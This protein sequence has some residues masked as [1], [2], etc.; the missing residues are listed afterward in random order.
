MLKETALGIVPAVTP[1]INIS[2]Q[3]GELPEE[4]KIAHATPI[5]K[6]LNSIPEN[7][8]PISL[9]SALSKLLEMH[10]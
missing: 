2:I 4:W 1:L 6:S 10:V 8:C 9:L 7:Y 3:V 5:P